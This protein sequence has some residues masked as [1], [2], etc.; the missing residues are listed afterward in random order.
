L[1]RTPAAPAYA[2]AL[3]VPPVVSAWLVCN[4]LFPS[5]WVG[6]EVWGWE[7]DEPHSLHFLNSFTVIADPMLGHVEFGATVRKS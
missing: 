1:I 4:S 2:A 3:L 6:Q 7:H 5:L